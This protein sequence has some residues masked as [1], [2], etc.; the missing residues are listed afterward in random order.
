MNYITRVLAGLFPPENRVV[1]GV[2]SARTFGQ[3]LRSSIYTIAGGGAALTAS[4]VIGLDWAVVG[5][6]VIGAVVVATLA[7]ADAWWDVAQH[8]L[9]E[10][11][12]QALAAS[13]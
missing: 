9:N 4:D 6:G 13:K 10:K 7:A 11:Y 3:S 5:I 12:R 2:A 8:G 1:A